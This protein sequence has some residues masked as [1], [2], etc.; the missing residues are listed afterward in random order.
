[1][2]KKLISNIIHLI[3]KQKCLGCGCSKTGE[4]LC[5]TC[6]KELK[7]STVYAQGV[8]E[9]VKIFS[10][11]EYNGAIKKLIHQLKY[12]HKKGASKVLAKLLYEYFLKIKLGENLIIIPVPSH[13]QRVLRR[14]YC[15]T[16]LICEEFSRLSGLKVET[17]ILKKIKNTKPQYKLSVEKRRKNLA[18]SF[19]LNLK[20]YSGENILLVDDIFTTGA[21]LEEIINLFKKESVHNFTALTVCKTSLHSFEQAC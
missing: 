9:G 10:A 15:Q 8:Y 12:N 16:N 19:A 2:F 1:V 13:Q 20:D 14:G 3:Y 21:T 11:L 5:K 18:D 17:K 7:F 6:E 4:I